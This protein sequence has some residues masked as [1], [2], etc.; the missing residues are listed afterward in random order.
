MFI[1]V[2]CLVTA[3]CIDSRKRWRRRE[4]AATLAQDGRKTVPW[5]VRVG[6]SKD[7]LD[8]MESGIL[9]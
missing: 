1:V 8:S 4:G 6:K 2:G 9:V 7:P 3:E 5:L